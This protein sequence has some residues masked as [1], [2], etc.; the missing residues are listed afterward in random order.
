MSLYTFTAFRI[1]KKNIAALLRQCGMPNDEALELPLS[2]ADMER[3]ALR[4]YDIRTFGLSRDAQLR[5]LWAERELRERAQESPG[6][7]CL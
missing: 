4:E 6:L 1:H 3:L 5:A 2:A 7:I